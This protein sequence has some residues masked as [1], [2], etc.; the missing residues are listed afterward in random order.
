M[1]RFVTE[2]FTQEHQELLH[3]L[4]D[5]QKELRVLPM[6]RNARQACE[7]LQRL[8]QHVARGLHTHFEEEEIVLYPAL[9]GHMQGIH[10]TLERMKSEHVA[11]EA[12]EK[13]FLDSVKRMAEASKNRQEV[14]RAGLAYVNWTRGHLLSENG[15]LFPLVDRSL[16]AQAQKQIR[17]AMEELSRETTA[18]IA[19][20]F[21][22]EAPS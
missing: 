4:D 5:L 3:L 19:E 1:G 10:N 6:A 22:Q 13:K 7:R 14:M 16:D 2:Y 8:C 12:A 18:R 20:S 15:R 17:Q 9:E 21:P 11:G